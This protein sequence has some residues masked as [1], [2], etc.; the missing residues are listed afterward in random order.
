M[1]DPFVGGTGMLASYGKNNT[2]Y[3]NTGGTSF[4]NFSGGTDFS[5]FN[6]QSSLAKMAAP[7]PESP[8]LRPIEAIKQF[9]YQGFG[10]KVGSFL[11]KVSPV[12]GA[13]GAI[14]GFV[15]SISAR[16][17]ARREARKRKKLAISSENLLVG[18]AKNVI[19]DINQ[20]EL[21]TGRAYDAMQ[22]QG[23]FEFKGSL[24]QGDASIGRTGLAGTGTGT[25]ILQ[26]IKSQYTMSQDRASLDYERNLYGLEQ[27]ELSR[28]RDIQGNL[29][30]LSAYSGRNINV[31]EMMGRE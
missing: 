14:A 1:P 5:L 17:R 26:D 10:G 6:Q 7:T 12:L 22:K 3:T 20:Q 16:R 11:G 18:A 13:V 15:G 27:Q 29:L 19:M 9:D 24:E 21:F 28:L 31:L 2:N 25:K 4:G 30:Q 23:A 8:G